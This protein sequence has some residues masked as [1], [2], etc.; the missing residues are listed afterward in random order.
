VSNTVFVLY[1]SFGAK[2]T[3]C[4]FLFLQKSVKL[5][6]VN[7]SFLN[8]QWPL[9]A[10]RGNFKVTIFWSVW[11]ILQNVPCLHF[12]TW[13]VTELFRGKIIR[14]YWKYSANWKKKMNNYVIVISILNPYKYSYDKYHKLSFLMSQA[15]FVYKIVKLTMC[16][17]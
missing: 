12:G 16:K 1:W 13:G 3:Y 4:F 14:F 5:S 2:T 10:S 9:F 11:K 6:R 15:W 7:I 8:H 17:T